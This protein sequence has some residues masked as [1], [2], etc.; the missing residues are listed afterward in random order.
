MDSDSSGQE[1]KSPITWAHTNTAKAIYDKTKV[2]S[3]DMRRESTPAEKHLWQR[4]RKEQLLGFKFRRQ[5]TIDRFIVD[6]YCAKAHLVVEVDGNI[7]NEQ[8]EADQH[9]TEVLES[10]GLR[11][12]RFTNGEVLQQTDAVIERIAETLQLC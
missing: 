1:V 2:L 7:H 8:Q 10:L 12:L 9:R 6:F 4:L 3:R 5:H 11:V